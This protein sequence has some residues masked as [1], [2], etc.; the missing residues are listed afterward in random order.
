[1]TTQPVAE[2]GFDPD[3]LRRQYRQARDRRA[4]RCAGLETRPGGR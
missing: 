1:M 3:T 4:D 2:L